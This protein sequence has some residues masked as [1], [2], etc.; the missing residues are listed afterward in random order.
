MKSLI[1]PCGVLLCIFALTACLLEEP[2]AATKQQSST[3]NSADVQVPRE[4]TFE[5]TQSSCTTSSGG[6]Y[7]DGTCRVEMI[8]HDPRTNCTPSF[9]RNGGCNGQ[10]FNIAVILCSEHCASATCTNAAPHC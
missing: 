6:L 4:L 3:A 9:C 8:C 1:V 10:A 5:R 2:E 7:D